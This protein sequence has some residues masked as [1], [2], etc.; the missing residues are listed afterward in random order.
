MKAGEQS[1]TARDTRAERIPTLKFEHTKHGL[2]H[3]PRGAQ[4]TLEWR[5]RTLLGDV[6]GCRRDEI[7]GAILLSVRHFDGTPWPIEP[8]S[9]AV[10]V[11]AR[12]YEV[13]P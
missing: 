5:G 8:T 4:V 12:D 7:T 3:D 9:R 2:K 10:D 13:E 11:L 1:T 6:V